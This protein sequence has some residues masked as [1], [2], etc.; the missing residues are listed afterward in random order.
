MTNKLLALIHDRNIRILT[1]RTDR[2]LTLLTH[3]DDRLLIAMLGENRDPL[4][5]TV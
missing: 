4:K 2:E 5:G 3:H 1:L